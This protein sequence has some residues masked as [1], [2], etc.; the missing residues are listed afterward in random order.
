MAAAAVSLYKVGA[1]LQRIAATDGMHG[2]S[3]HPSSPSVCVG[4][5]VRVHQFWLSTN[6]PRP[7]PHVRMRSTGADAPW[8]TTWGSC[9]SMERCRAAC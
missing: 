9:F 7:T 5:P 1:L 4:S 2:G 3:P 6:H 8:T